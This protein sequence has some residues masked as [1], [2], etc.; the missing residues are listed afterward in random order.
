MAY[1]FPRR[2]F[3]TRWL[4]GALD[5]RRSAS[6]PLAF[7]AWV[8]DGLMLALAKAAFIWVVRLLL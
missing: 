8:G 1:W 7:G 6:R 2:A 4:A 3:F 5:L